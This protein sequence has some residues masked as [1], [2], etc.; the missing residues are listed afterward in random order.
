MSWKKTSCVNCALNCG[1]EVQ[2]ENNRIVKVRPDKNNPRSEGYVCRKGLNVACHQHNA[3][4]VLYPLK[5]VGDQFERVPWD[6]AIGEIAEKMAEIGLNTQDKGA[7]ATAM[8]ACLM[9]MA[10]HGAI[11][12]GQ[13][14]ADQEIK[15]LLKRAPGETFTRVKLLDREL[16]AGEPAF[17][18]LDRQL[19][20]IHASAP[21]LK[22]EIDALEEVPHGHVMRS[23]DAFMKAGVEDIEFRGAKE[24]EA[25]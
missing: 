12:A 10:C 16:G 3:D 7:L 8:D 25:R 14:L 23:I 5:R 21:E 17:A 24:K 11:R 4:R 18:E 19:A 13:P 15:V 20:A 9:L 1:L 22:G 2:V 6:Q